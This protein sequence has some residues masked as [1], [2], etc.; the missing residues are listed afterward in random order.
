M[1]AA[2]CG[3]HIDHENRL[4][5][6][7]SDVQDLWKHREKDREVNEKAHARIHG[8]IDAMKNWVM[9]GMASMI[10]YFG[11]TILKFVLDWIAKGG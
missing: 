2:N 11:I 9:G 10:L 1:M 6:N 7:E 5:R 4:K 3:E 8:R